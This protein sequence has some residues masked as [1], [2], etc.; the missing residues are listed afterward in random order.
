METPNRTGLAII[1]SLLALVL[2]DAMGLIIK[3]LSTEFSAAELSTWRN[4][5]GILPAFL[6]LYASKTWRENGKK[7]II[8]QWKLALLRG[9]IASLAQLCFYWSLGLMAFATASTITYSGALFAT[10]FAIP[11]LGERVGIVRWLAVIIGFLGVVFILQ[12]GS[13]AFTHYSILPLAAA[14]F[15]ALLTITA[16]LFDSQVS[17]ALV[18]VYASLSSTVCAAILTLF[19][20]GFSPISSLDEIFWIIMMGAFGGS[21]VL[22]YVVSYR[23]T[24]QSNLAPFSYFGI[25]I[26]FFF[27][28]AFFDETPWDAIFPGGILIISGG[29]LIFWRERS[30]KR[31]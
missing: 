24:E 3:L 5:F 17:S 19:L 18:N 6:V 29:L 1:L 15:Y 11:I 13:D 26:A 7:I 28:W 31:S 10:A 23:M 14:A 2:F 22:L 12:P 9:V 25:P 20:G 16:K 8:K 4:L 27:G 21:A 30:F